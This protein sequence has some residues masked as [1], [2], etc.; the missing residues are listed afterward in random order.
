MA[1]TITPTSHGRCLI[2]YRLILLNAPSETGSAS[3][4]SAC[5]ACASISFVANNPH[6]ATSH[7]AP[8]ADASAVDINRSCT[9]ST[10]VSAFRHRPIPPAFSCLPHSSSTTTVLHDGSGSGNSGPPPPLRNDSLVGRRLVLRC[11]VMFHAVWTMR[12]V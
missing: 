10:I 2:R 1:D 11:G 6:S 3:S 12:H 4:N 8:L 9:R 5:V 7:Q